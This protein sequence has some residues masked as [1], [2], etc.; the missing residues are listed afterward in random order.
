M[1]PEITSHHSQLKQEP[2]KRQQ[3]SPY[4]EEPRRRDA[5][6]QTAPFTLVRSGWFLQPFSLPTTMS[7]CNETACGR[8]VGI[9]DF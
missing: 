8:F 5:Q 7:M 4:L 3:R 9:L 1:S 2:R 6:P